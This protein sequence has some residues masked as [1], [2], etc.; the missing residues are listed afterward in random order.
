MKLSM[1]GKAVK[2]ILEAQ[3]LY[4]WDDCK[5]STYFSLLGSRMARFKAVGFVTFRMFFIHDRICHSD[6]ML[7]DE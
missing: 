6:S 5:S 4:I 3:I 2:G 7:A 1:S